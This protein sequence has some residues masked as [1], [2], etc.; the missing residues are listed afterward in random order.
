M[1]ER[2]SLL[3][4]P[5]WFPVKAV[6]ESIADF[7]ACVVAVIRRHV[8]DVQEGAVSVRASKAGRYTAVTVMIRADSQQQL[9]AIYQDLSA[10]PQVLMAL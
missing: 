1:N 5:C 8:A 3:E 4:F 2:S 6:G 9:D 10:C 7:D